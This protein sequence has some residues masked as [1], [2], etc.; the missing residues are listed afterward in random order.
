MAGDRGH[1]YSIVRPHEWTWLRVGGGLPCTGLHGTVSTAPGKSLLIFLHLSPTTFPP[2]MQ[3]WLRGGSQSGEMGKAEKH[4]GFRPRSL[5]LP[6]LKP[7]AGQGSGAL[8]LHGYSGREVL[9][10][11]VAFCPC[12]SL[13]I[14]SQNQWSTRT[15]VKTGLGHQSAWG[16][17]ANAWKWAPALGHICMDFMLRS[18]SMPK[19]TFDSYRKCTISSSMVMRMCWEHL[20]FCFQAR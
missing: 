14:E 12:Q 5:T 19:T 17:N 11:G 8:E 18:R 6:G 20:A 4:Q 16:R 3:G 9:W 10:V 1:Y 7:W 13:H 2:H 15:C